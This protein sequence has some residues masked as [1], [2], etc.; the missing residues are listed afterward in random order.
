[1]TPSSRRIM[2][3]EMVGWIVGQ[4]VLPLSFIGSSLTL[5]CGA[6]LKASGAAITRAPY[7]LAFYSIS[8][9]LPALRGSHCLLWTG[10]EKRVI[11]GIHAV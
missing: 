8:V 9:A 6:L 4:A 11:P 5:P 10:I 2:P 7:F 1:M 3:W